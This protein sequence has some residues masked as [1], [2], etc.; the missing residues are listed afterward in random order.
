VVSSNRWRE[1]YCCKP[2]TTTSAGVGGSGKGCKPG[3][4]DGA[5]DLEVRARLRLGERKRCL[6]VRWKDGSKKKHGGGKGRGGVEGGLR[7]DG[8][9]EERSKSKHTKGL[10]RRK[11]STCRLRPF[12]KGSYDER[13]GERASLVSSVT[14]CM[15]EKKTVRQDRCVPGGETQT[16][17]DHRPAEGV[18]RLMEKKITLMLH[19]RNPASGGERSKHQG[20]Q[21]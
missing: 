13:G 11:K 8:R 15:E 14:D 6:V 10:N 5:V 12:Q 16:W 4:S 9:W 1:T 2:C 17:L 19:I 21:Q 3:S 20:S 7:G 18:V